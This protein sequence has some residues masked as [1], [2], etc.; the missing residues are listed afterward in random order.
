M[1]GVLP[2]DDHPHAVEGRMVEGGEYLAARRVAG[3]LAPFGHEEVL[4]L[5]EVGCLKLR[6]QHLI[7]TGIY[8]YCHDIYLF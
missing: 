2:Q 8:L 3:V 5:G 1:I 7:P 6:L 4:E